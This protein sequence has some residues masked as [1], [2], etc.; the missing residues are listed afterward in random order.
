MEDGHRLSSSGSQSELKEQLNHI[1]VVGRAWTVAYYLPS[2]WDNRAYGVSI[3]TFN[4]HQ[5]WVTF[6]RGLAARRVDQQIQYK[7]EMG[8]S[9]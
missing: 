6:D 4:C 2:T 3:I 5:M 8:P 1:A 9:G 7:A